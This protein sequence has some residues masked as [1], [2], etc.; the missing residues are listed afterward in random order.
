MRQRRFKIVAVRVVLNYPDVQ[1]S[2]MLS[3]S[4]V[5]NLQL[6]RLNDSSVPVSK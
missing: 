6:S 2:M 1:M 5:Q 3:R 4:S